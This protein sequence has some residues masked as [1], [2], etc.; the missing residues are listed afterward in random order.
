MI[1]ELNNIKEISFLNS[2]YQKQQKSKKYEIYF[3]YNKMLYKTS[4]KHLEDKILKLDKTSQKRGG[5]K[6]LRLKLLKEYKQQIVEEGNAI[7]I[8][9]VEKFNK[10]CRN[11]NLNKGECCEYLSCKARNLEYKR[12]NTRY[13][14][15][16]DINLKRTS[17]QVKFQNATIASVDTI[18]KLAK[19]LK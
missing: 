11:Q 17:I 13:D 9:S 16:G 7:K 1:K 14:K 3:I 19:N 12:N 6:T 15:A 10:T 8:M 2:L 5:K 4:I 18:L